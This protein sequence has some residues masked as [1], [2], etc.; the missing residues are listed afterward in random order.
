M[1]NK[2]DKCLAWFI[3]KKRGGSSHCGPEVKNPTGIHEDVGSIPGPA[4]R[5]KGS[6]IAVSCGV[7]QQLQLLLTPS[8]ETSISCGCDPKKTK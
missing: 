8:V 3:K 5:V 2:I 1:I 6:S 7:G 4:Q